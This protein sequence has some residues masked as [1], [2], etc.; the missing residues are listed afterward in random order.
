MILSLARA[1]ATDSELLLLDEP[2]AG[3]APKMVDRVLEVV[4]GMMNKDRTVI[5]IEHNLEVVTAVVQTVWI[6]DAGRQVASG[7]PAEMWGR[8]DVLHTYLGI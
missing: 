4:T 6:M 3:L 8:P 1:L 2:T 7:T 5:M